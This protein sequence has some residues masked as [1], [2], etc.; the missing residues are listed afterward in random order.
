VPSAEEF[1]K[2]ADEHFEWANSA[3]TEHER[4]IFLQMAAAWVVVAQA[5][6]ASAGCAGN[7]GEASASRCCGAAGRQ[8]LSDRISGARSTRA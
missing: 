7:E 3:K 5:W 2:N 1:Y 8:R 4:A 6:E